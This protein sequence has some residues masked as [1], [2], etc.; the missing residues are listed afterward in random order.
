MLRFAHI[1]TGTTAPVKIWPSKMT[2]TKLICHFLDIYDVKSHTTERWPEKENAMITYAEIGI[3][4]RESNGSLLKDREDWLV[5]AVNYGGTSLLEISNFEAA[6]SILGGESEDVNIRYLM[7]CDIILVRPGT[8]AADT[9]EV[10]ERQLDEYAALDETDLC[11][12]EGEEYLYSW[13][14]WSRDAFIA[15][16]SKKFV[17]NEDEFNL[18]DDANLTEVRKFYERVNDGILYDHEGSPDIDD[19]V[20]TCTPEDVQ[21]FLDLLRHAQSVSVGHA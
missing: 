17:F 1:P 14:C 10:I 4:R 12:R 5:A 20:R 13:E 3:T 2:R 8:K 11:E 18:L 16:L 6:G 21:S 15:A 19:A 7:Y 9:A